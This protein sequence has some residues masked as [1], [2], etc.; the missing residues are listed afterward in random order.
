MVC[1]CVEF[2]GKK[3]KSSQKKWGHVFKIYGI[4]LSMLFQLFTPQIR[5]KCHELDLFIWM[6]CLNGFKSYTTPTS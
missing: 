3:K 6:L 4:L 1:L 5:Y 2:R